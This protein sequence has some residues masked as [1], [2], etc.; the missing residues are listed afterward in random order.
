MTHFRPVSDVVIFISLFTDSLYTIAK[1]SPVHLVTKISP[2]PLS[3]QIIFGPMFSGKTTE[4]I[5]RLK[6]YE[7][8]N[9]KC[10]IV[11]VIFDYF[12]YFR[13]EF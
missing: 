13:T 10:L 12:I 6:R 2:L 1:I 3:T 5:R 11:K 8:A 4:L 9:H 7:V